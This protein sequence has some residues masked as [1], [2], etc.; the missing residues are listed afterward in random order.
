MKQKE[1]TVNL[2][3][4][5]SGKLCKSNEPS[6]IWLLWQNVLPHMQMQHAKEQYYPNQNQFGSNVNPLKS[7]ILKYSEREVSDLLKT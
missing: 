7:T 4:V 6:K 5:M 1:H 2:C 3:Q